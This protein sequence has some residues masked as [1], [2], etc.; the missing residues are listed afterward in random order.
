MK[1]GASGAETPKACIC[2][3]G[4]WVRCVDL[5]DLTSYSMFLSV[6]HT[7]CTSKLVLTPGVD[8][9]V[10]KRIL[11]VFSGFVPRICLATSL[12]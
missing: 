8:L 1:D 6:P 12:V 10:L 9:N 5:K 2:R 4:K 3:V 7:E 11:Y